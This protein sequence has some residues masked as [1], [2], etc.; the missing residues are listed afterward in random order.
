VGK[1]LR[2]RWPDR[3]MALSSHLKLDNA[4]LNAWRAAADAIVTGLDS[5]TGLYEQFTGYFGL[6]QIDLSAYAGRSVPMDVVLGR[7]RTQASQIIKQADVVA[8]LALLPEAFTGDTGRAN[9]RYYERRCGQGSSLSAALHGLVAARLGDG[10]MA[11]RYFRKTAAIDLA[12]GQAAGA[13]GVHIAALGGLWMMVVFGFAGLS[14]L[15]DGVAL[16]PRLPSDWTRLAFPVQ[17]RGRRIRV[18]IDQVTRRL[19][20]TL[21]AG[22][23]MTVVVAGVRHQLRTGQ[24]LSVHVGAP[25]PTADR[26]L[27]LSEPPL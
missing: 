6:E 23:A 15:S 18:A 24:P 17:W 5:K 4:E 7:E 10:E 16:D 3:W 2:E 14:L 20:A 11:M 22:A 1:L 21:E 8:L 26:T 12:D 27:E 19:E 25:H 13:G 9:F